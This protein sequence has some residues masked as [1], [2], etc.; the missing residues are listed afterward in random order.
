MQMFHVAA[1]L[2]LQP[3][4]HANKGNIGDSFKSETLVKC[5]NGRL[6]LFDNFPFFLNMF[7]IFFYFMSAPFTFTKKLDVRTLP[8]HHLYY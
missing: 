5:F 1:S 3:S 7:F 8:K 2:S 6:I 4:L